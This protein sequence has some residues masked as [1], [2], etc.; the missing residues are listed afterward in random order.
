MDVNA[1]VLML[2]IAAAT[3][4]SEDLTC[5]SAGVMA[6]QGR[7]DLGLAIFACFLGILAGDLLLF[8]AGRHL[9]RPAI[10]RAPLKWLIRAADVERGSAWFSRRGAIVIFISRFVP[11]MRLPTYVAA[12][13]LKTSFWRFTLYFSLAAAIWTPLLVALSSALGAEV[14][15]SALLAKQSFLVKALAVGVVVYLAIKLMTRLSTWRGR[16]QMISSWRRMTRWEF[17]PPWI[18]YPPVI[19]YVVYLILK[20]RSLTLFTAANP[21]IPGGGFVGESKIDILRGLAH[22]DGYVARAALIDAALGCEARVRQAKRFM[23]EQELSFPVVLKPN[24]GQRGSGVAVIRFEAELN[25]YLSR[26][27]VDTIIQE[28]V[29]GSEFGV[30]YYRLPGEDKGC[31]FSITEKRFPVMI[32]DGA[33]TLEELI[34]SDER[35][36][37]LA[38]FYLN[39]QRA[40]AQEVPDK[41]ERVQLVELGTHCRGAIFLDGDWVKTQALEERFDQISCGFDGF[42]FGRFDLRTPSIEEFKQG[43]N[44]K[45]VELNGVTS[46]ATHIYDPKNSL[47][48][49]YRILFEQWRI[50]FEIG[51]RNLRRGAQ[52]TSI[53]T[54]VKLMIAYQESAKFHAVEYAAQP[55]LGKESNLC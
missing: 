42:Y 55:A 27:A 24:Q 50:A 20:Y 6:A 43:K 11:G 34:L 45:I 1:F 35:A 47:F 53:S 8:L 14:L 22:A 52:L 30:F 33:S 17:W 9:G 51:A 41:G 39:K 4:L 3:L 21:A 31:I 28:Y 16:R 29:P 13:L 48:A 44:F 23:A 46:E 36:V 10:E 26:S 18:F 32:G 40:R 19:C 25:E 2:L 5:I 37:C 15:K 54:L 7:I 12:G 38:R 49:A